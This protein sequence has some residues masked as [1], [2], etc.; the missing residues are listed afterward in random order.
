MRYV[1][2][3]AE[4]EAFEARNEA[5]EEKKSKLIMY[6]TMPQKALAAD[7]VFHLCRH[8]LTRMGSQ[9]VDVP[10]APLRRRIQVAGALAQPKER[11]QIFRK[12]RRKMWA[13]NLPNGLKSKLP[14]TTPL[15]REVTQRPQI[16]KCELLVLIPRELLVLIPP[17][18]PLVVI[19]RELLVP[20][21][22]EHL[23]LVPRELLVLAR[24]LL[25]MIPRELRV[26]IP[27][28]LLVLIPHHPRLYALTLFH[29][30]APISTRMST[31]TLAQNTHFL[32]RSL[33][34][35]ESRES[36]VSMTLPHVTRV[37]L[38]ISHIARTRHSIE[39]TATTRLCL[40]STSLI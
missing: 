28:E 18:E 9:I 25:V 39:V 24:E 7:P 11:A 34:R 32:T 26:L 23:V 4:F 21:P 35:I 10:R 36:Q 15:V 1:G 38:R 17:R 20:I 33:G 19:P 2:L 3:V 30:R 14:H 40:L 5:K 27:R 6:T 22:R 37:F 12:V 29:L 13:A 16:L 31:T 8:L